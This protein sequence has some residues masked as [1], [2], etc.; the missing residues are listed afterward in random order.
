MFY[1][2]REATPFTIV[3]LKRVVKR[4]GTVLGRESEAI[5]NEL[6]TTSFFGFTTIYCSMCPL[7]ICLQ[8]EF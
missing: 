6:L 3:Y 8:H 1:G 4:R 2:R 5:E 7:S